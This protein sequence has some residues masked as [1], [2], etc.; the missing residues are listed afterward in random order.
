MG[1]TWLYKAW[2]GSEG[3]LLNFYLL[4]AATVAIYLG[5]AV[6]QRRNQN[7]RE[8]AKNALYAEDGR[9]EFAVNDRMLHSSGASA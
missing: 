5:A 7:N 2:K 1:T 3:L 4:L 8:K 9:K 6:L